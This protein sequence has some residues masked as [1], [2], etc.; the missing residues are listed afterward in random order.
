[1][2]SH[3]SLLKVTQ[4]VVHKGKTRRVPRVRGREEEGRGEKKQI[5]AKAITKARVSL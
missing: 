3:I 5:K 2:G 4:Q 1:M